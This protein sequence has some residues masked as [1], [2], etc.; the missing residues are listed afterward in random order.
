MSDESKF[1]GNVSFRAKELTA[2]LVEIESKHGWPPGKFAELLTKA[3]C[4]FYRQHEWFNF[5]VKIEPVDM[6]MRRV[7]EE[8]AIYEAGKKYLDSE[9]KKKRTPKSG[10]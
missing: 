3:A 9:A 10:P 2:T 7:A 8:Q 5:P 1:S 4:D 6:H